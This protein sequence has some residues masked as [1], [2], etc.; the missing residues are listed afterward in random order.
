LLVAA[1]LTLY[2]VGVQTTALIILVIIC[3]SVG[4]GFF[5]EYRSEL[6]VEALHAQPRHTAL[7]IRGGETETVD[8][9]H[10]VRLVV[11]TVRGRPSSRPWRSSAAK[12]TAR[13][14]NSPRSSGRPSSRASSPSAR[15][16]PTAASSRPTGATG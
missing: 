10:L 8:V 5:N 1:A 11:G 7:A 6:A 2:A 4:L 9:T 3:G 12:E 14:P 13:R 16:W 15:R